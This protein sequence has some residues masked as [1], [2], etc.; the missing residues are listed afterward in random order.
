MKTSVNFYSPLNNLVRN[1]LFDRASSCYT[2]TFKDEGLFNEKSPLA[3]EI[4]LFHKTYR[5]KNT[6][7]EKKKKKDE[8][9]GVGWGTEKGVK[10]L[11]TLP[12][13]RL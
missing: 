2:K 11:I 12:G 10:C 5:G 6:D 13:R 4:C 8:E 3:L 1:M 7:S 9:K